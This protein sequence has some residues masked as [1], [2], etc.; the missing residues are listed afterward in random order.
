DQLFTNAHTLFRDTTIQ[1]Y[2][3]IE[4]LTH[5]IDQNQTKLNVLNKLSLQ[6]SSTN[7]IH[8]ISVYNLATQ[9]VLS[10]DSKTHINEGKFNHE[11]PDEWTYTTREPNSSYNKF[12]RFYITHS[13]DL[14]KEPHKAKAVMEIKLSTDEIIKM[15]NQYQSP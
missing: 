7:L 14:L 2:S 10:S 4:S 3:E 13:S 9:E 15:L 1:D 6:T 12:L 8:H 5:L 11:L